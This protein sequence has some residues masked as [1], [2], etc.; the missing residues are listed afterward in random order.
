MR[1]L[2]QAAQLDLRCHCEVG[3]G[4]IH[5]RLAGNDSGLVL[6]DNARLLYGLN[7]LVG[8][9]FFKRTHGQYSF[10][11][12]CNDYRATR[13]LELELLARK[14]AE[15][16]AF[17]GKPFSL[18]PMPATERRVIHLA[19]ADEAGVVTESEGNGRHR[20]VVILPASEVR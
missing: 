19:L 11:V 1:R 8:Q 20:R 7:H 15:K 12:D 6:R 10:V 3:E 14:A 16:V 17:S 4:V 13:V 5:L 9:A 18:Q 2:V